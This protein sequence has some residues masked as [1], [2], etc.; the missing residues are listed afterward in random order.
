MFKDQ[1]LKYVI[2]G[3]TIVVSSKPP[4][5]E[6]A[7]WPP[8]IVSPA[9]DTVI[10]NGRVVDENHEPV[11]GANVIVARTKQG[12]AT[13]KNGE[14][15]IKVR[16]DDLI[17][18]TFI[19]FE[20]YSYRAKSNL[21]VLINLKKSET[22][23]KE[24]IVTGL[25]DRKQT[26]F[27]GA[28][29]TY[30]QKELMQAGNK[31]VLQSL[32]NIDPSFR[33]MENLNLGADPNRLPEIQM[34][35]QSSLPNLQGDYS[36]NP[37][38]PLFILDGFET[39]L[40]RVFDLNMNRIASVTLLKDA[41]AK[42]IY[43]SRAANGVVVIETIRPARGKLRVSYTGE[44]AV[45]APDLSGYNLMEAA[46][47]LAFEKERGMYRRFVYSPRDIQG[48]RHDLPGQLRKCA[49]RCE[50]LLAESAIANRHHNEACTQPGRG[51]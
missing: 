33:V 24:V 18:I 13:D 23:I 50:Y 31:N 42:A 41:A 43:G 34:R 11:A 48:K 5:S 17:E 10:V 9:K 1:P 32:K 47:K 51:R 40:Q 19:G 37:N 6:D 36:G 4:P 29:V 38:Q 15:S 44:A 22:S 25:V 46:D 28:A 14:F 12:I 49:A 45:E 16:L 27:T 26:S 3:K 20:K 21:R 7:S 2:E 8:E 39:T 35:G 30:T